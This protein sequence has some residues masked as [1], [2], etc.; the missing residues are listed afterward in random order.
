MEST[1]ILGAKANIKFHVFAVIAFF[2]IHGIFPNFIFFKYCL[3]IF[4][5]ICFSRLRIQMSA[6]IF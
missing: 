5:K 2:F 3:Y 1:V 4:S 6:L